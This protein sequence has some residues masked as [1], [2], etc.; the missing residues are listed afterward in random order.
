[1]RLRRYT[2]MLTSHNQMELGTAMLWNIADGLSRLVRQGR[3]ALPSMRLAY[4]AENWIPT[5][6]CAHIWRVIPA[7]KTKSESN[8][9]I[10]ANAPDWE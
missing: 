1:V 2:A 5:P 10:G 8:F 9:M 3:S 7:S 4:E 6:R